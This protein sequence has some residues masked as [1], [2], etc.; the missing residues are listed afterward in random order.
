MEENASRHMGGSFGSGKDLREEARIA[1]SPSGDSNEAWVAG[2]ERTRTWSDYRVGDCKVTS[3]RTCPNPELR[4]VK[5]R[6][7]MEGSAVVE[8]P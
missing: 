6:G 1:S 5:F 4:S 8:E 3:S 7:V 2:Q